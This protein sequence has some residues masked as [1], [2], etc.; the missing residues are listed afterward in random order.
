MEERIKNPH[1]NNTVTNSGVI[2]VDLIFNTGFNASNF[3]A[4]WQVIAQQSYSTDAIFLLQDKIQPIIKLNEKFDDVKNAD[5]CYFTTTNEDG[6]SSKTFYIINN[7]VAINQHNTLLNLQLDP[8]CTI[9]LENIAIIAGW[10]LRAHPL[11]DE[12]FMNVIPESF[13]PIYPTKLQHEVV[14]FGDEYVDLIAST[15]DLVNLQPKLDKIYNAERTSYEFFKLVNEARKFTK[16]YFP[17][18]KNAERHHKVLNFTTLFELKDIPSGTFQLLQGLGLLNSIIA[19]YRVPKRF[20]HRIEKDA[21][22]RIIELVGDGVGFNI[23]LPFVYNQNLNIKYKKVFSILN[24]YTVSSVTNGSQS[25]FTAY[26][27]NNNQPQPSFILEPDVSP[28][29]NA[30]LFPDFY[31]GENRDDASNFS[32]SITG[33]N[34]QNNPLLSLNNSGYLFNNALSNIA[35]KQSSTNI[36]YLNA[37]SGLL[38]DM[39]TNA[40]VG[41]NSSYDTNIGDLDRQL[42]FNRRTKIGQVSATVAQNLKNPMQWIGLAG[43]IGMW[44]YDKINGSPDTERPLLSPSSIQNLSINNNMANLQAN[45]DNLATQQNVTL[46]KGQLDL[47]SSQNSIENAINNTIFNNQREQLNYTRNTY[48]TP[49]VINFPISNNLQYYF[50]NTFVITQEVLDERDLI[51]FNEYFSRFGYSVSEQLTNTHLNSYTHFNYIQANGLII[52]DKTKIL[53]K[54]ILDMIIRLFEVGVRIW[55]RPIT[56]DAFLHNAK[57]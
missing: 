12:L 48:S 33:N 52:K 38:Q 17:S 18:R 4:N 56:K 19:S 30:F 2:N 14:S 51:R 53:P 36:S 40:N 24:N 23:N 35:A 3:P 55:H 54:Y 28:N 22:N 21:E 31:K 50:D 44:G 8:I 29:G 34:W 43:E 42:S 9:G 26:E 5:Y 39:L 47:I 25:S 32:V 15:V 27:I 1:T 6:N 41:I 57:R 37:K 7:I 13:T 16:I 20:I 45:I 49:P 11:Q 10:A 46:N